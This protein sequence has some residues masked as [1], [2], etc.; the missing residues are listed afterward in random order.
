MRVQVGIKERSFVICAP[1]ENDAIAKLHEQLGEE[2]RLYS[3]TQ[4][5][6]C[7]DVP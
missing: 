4:G 1:S 2:V 3:A 7:G 6:Y 5:D